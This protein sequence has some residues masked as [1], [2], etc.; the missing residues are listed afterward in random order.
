MMPNPAD[1]ERIL[2]ML[3]GAAP[4]GVGDTPVGTDAVPTPDLS[5][6]GPAPA[7]APPEPNS[8]A[9]VAQAPDMTPEERAQLQASLELAAR[10]ELLKG[11]APQGI[12]AIR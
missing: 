11:S 9:A 2:E 7:E 1:R 4:T 12:G 8:A 3:G 5:G 6:A 10:E